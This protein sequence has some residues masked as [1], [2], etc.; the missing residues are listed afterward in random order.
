MVKTLG[1]CGVRGENL[2]EQRPSPI[3]SYWC[4]GSGAA[5]CEQNQSPD[6]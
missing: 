3:G 1:A 4:R 5:R 6:S 2:L